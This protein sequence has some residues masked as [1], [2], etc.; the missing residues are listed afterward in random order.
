ML[1]LRVATHGSGSVR[2]RIFLTAMSVSLLTLPSA[3]GAR[4]ADVTANPASNPRQM[5]PAQLP[6]SKIGK[7][8]QGRIPIVFT[9]N[10][11]QAPA[12]VLYEAR[13]AGLD[14]LLGKTEVTLFHEVPQPAPARTDLGKANASSAGSSMTPAADPGTFTVDRQTIE[15]VGENPDVVVEPLDRQSGKASYFRGQ[16]PKHWSTGLSTYARVRY[17]NLND[18]DVVAIGQHELIYIDE[19]SHQ[20]HPVSEHGSTAVLSEKHKL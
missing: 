1:T 10:G 12:G 16:D 7:F 14:V 15:F 9:A 6:P 8:A 4:T 19:R 13:G 18:G 17:H 5:T 2:A 3:G 20:R 11:G